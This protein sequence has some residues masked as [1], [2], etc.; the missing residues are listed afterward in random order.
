MPSL[1]VVD[2]TEL[3]RTTIRTIV[4]EEDI[5]VSAV[6]E[7]E[8]GE[9]AVQLARLHQPDII[10]MDIKMPGMNG[11]Q[12]TAVIREEMPNT[13]IVMLTAYDEFTFVQE[14]LQL[15]AIDYLLKP[16]RPAKLI[17]VIRT[18]QTKL[19][20]DAERQ[21]VLTE[22]RER[23]LA[24]LPIVEANLVDDLIYTQSLGEDTIRQTL[25]QLHKEMSIAV[26][27]IVSIDDFDRVAKRAGPQKLLEKYSALSE[28]IQATVDNPAKMLFGLWQLGELAVILSTDF[29]WETIDAQKRLGEQIKHAIENALHTP[30]TISFGRRYSSISDIPISFAEARIARQYSKQ[31]ESGVIHIAEITGIA[32]PQ[33]YAYPLALEKELL[34]S[35]RLKQEDVSLELMNA[36]VDNLIYNYKDTPQILYSYFG[37]L[38]TLISR[39]VIDMGAL[40]QMV[41][42][43][44]HRQM[45]ILF[46]SPTPAQLRI[47]AINSVTE[48]LSLSASKKEEQ[49]ARDVVQLAIE[50]IHENHHNPDLT[51]GEVANVVG[52]SQSHLAHLLKE[53]MG[54]NYS[55]Y[56][57]SL[58]IRHAKKLLRTTSMTV[59]SI[60]ETVG[61]PNATHFYRIFQRQTEM[62]PKTYRETSIA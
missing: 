50:Y 41:L 54:M 15:G 36:L 20:K 40:S 22:A 42:E 45:T 60:A 17:E 8:N 53:R 4:G 62:T 28:V 43:H 16:V 21:H 25:Q 58:R 26:V 27:M 31:D 3:I 57:S 33:G 10:F 34:E 56:L 32:A 52:M 59:S 7:A 14:A 5:N 37:E 11:L 1:L 29:Q 38:L 19:R 2:D 13:K 12:A 39:S 46:S 23:L 55:K 24:M 51:L 35:I 18:A 61:Y 44:S 48:L 49:P 30:V 9:E 6:Y 47:W